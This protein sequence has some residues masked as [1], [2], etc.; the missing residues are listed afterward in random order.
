MEK[1]DSKEEKDKLSM[2]LENKINQTECDSKKSPL[3][4]LPNTD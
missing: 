1:A 2:Y 4:F 3:I